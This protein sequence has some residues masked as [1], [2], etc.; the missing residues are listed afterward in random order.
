[1][2]RGQVTARALML[3]SRTDNKSVHQ[4]K[5][6][7]RQQEGDGAQGRHAL[8]ALPGRAVSITG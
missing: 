4:E 6:S 5:L 7:G 3:P 1:M 2:I 8:P